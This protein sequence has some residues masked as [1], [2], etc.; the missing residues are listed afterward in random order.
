LH[1]KPVTLPKAQTAASGIIES[2]N[3]KQTKEQ[4]QSDSKSSSRSPLGLIGSTG[5]A[6]TESNIHKGGYQAIELIRITNLTPLLWVR[7]DPMALYGG[8]ISV[9]QPDACLAEMLFHDGDAG[10]QV[11]ALR[12]LAERP[13]KIQGSV[14]ISSVYDVPVSELPLRC[15]ADCLRGTPALH[16]S[17]P[18]TP[19][20]RAQA[21]LAIAQWQNNKAPKHKN[22]MGQSSWVGLQLLIQYF[23]ERFYNNETVMPV[24]FNR[25][26]VKK[27]DVETQQTVANPEGSAPAI[28]ASEDDGYRYLDAFDEGEERAEVLEEADEVDVEEDEEYRV[29]SAVTTA[30]ASIRAKDGMTPP[31]VVRFLETVLEAADAEMVGNIVTP[32][33]EVLMEKKRRK[34][35]DDTIEGD[36]ESVDEVEDVVVNSMPYSSSMLVA[37]AL[38]ALCHINVSPE[39]ITDP[40][41]GKSVQSTAMHPVAKL[42]ETSRRWLEWELFRERIRE[43]KE[44]QSLSGV[45]GVCHDTVAACAITALST[46]SILRQSTTDPL[47]D[48]TTN[49][50]SSEDRTSEQIRRDKL[51]EVARASYYISIFDSKP[52]RSDTTRAACAQ[53]VACI[54]CAADRFESE[55]E[56]PVGLLTALEFIF[57]RIVDPKTS[58]GLRQTLAQLMVDACSGKICSMQRVGAIGGRNDLINSAARFLNGPLGASYGGDTGSAVVTNVNPISYPAASAVNDGARRGL[59]LISRAGHPKEAGVGEELVVRVAQFATN[60]WRTINGEPIEIG[61]SIPGISRGDVGVCATDGQLRC[62]LLALFQW[63]WPR[64]PFAVLQVQVRKSNEW[65]KDYR[66]L[67]VNK[68]MKTSEEEKIAANEEE[69]SLAE[70]QRLVSIELDRQIW[71]GE[72]SM[73]AFNI[74]KTTKSSTTS[75]ADPGASEQGIGIPLPPIKRD[76]SFKQGG[77]IASSAQQR[78]AANLDGGVS[79]SKIRIR[80]STDQ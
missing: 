32:D 51:E 44:M 71:R 66:E 35:N 31:T 21:A 78:R 46:L 33:E 6:F 40:A 47:P 7:V 43:E 24:K 73:K 25:V 48:L 8:R 54:C 45:S 3:S 12:A 61:E 50:D 41:T 36:D 29:R 80:K 42:M 10:A 69:A 28:K 52:Q 16:S 34:V 4:K 79:V 57:Q 63:L 11:D 37:D 22:D 62:T 65:T 1:Q 15:L 74:Y 56:K 2:G 17:L 26:I 70:L 19:A 23:R 55:T 76:L 30:I 75:V 18:H 49:T 13:L 64:G 59:R 77:W 38:L 67:G 39:F 14:K 60:M 9:F 5:G 72:M 20:V 53:A 27:N 58:S 68:V